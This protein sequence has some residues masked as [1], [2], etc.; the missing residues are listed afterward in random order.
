MRGDVLVQEPGT[1]SGI[2]RESS[3]LK[4]EGRFG[5]IDHRPGCR[6]LVIGARWRRL[7]IDDDGV[8]DIDHVVEPIAKLDTLVRL[9]GPGGAWIAW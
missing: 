4:A 3:R 8:L 5:S 1:I 6:N 7:D 9:R 2:G